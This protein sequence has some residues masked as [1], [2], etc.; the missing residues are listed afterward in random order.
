MTY[1]PRSLTVIALALFCMSLALG[2]WVYLPFSNALYQD[3][4]WV[5]MWISEQPLG[6]QQPLTWKHVLPTLAGATIALFFFS[7]L[8]NRLQARRLAVAC[9]ICMFW[10]S[11]P[12]HVG[13]LQVH[14]PAAYAF[15]C[16]PVLIALLAAWRYPRFVWMLVLLTLAALALAASLYFQ[17]LPIPNPVA[18]FVPSASDVGPWAFPQ[19]FSPIVELA[20]LLLLLLLLMP[21][22]NHIAARLPEASTPL[23]V[24]A[25]LFVVRN[26][27]VGSELV[28]VRANPRLAL[29]HSLAYAQANPA[30]AWLAVEHFEFIGDEDSVSRYQDML[31]LPLPETTPLSYRIAVRCMV[32]GTYDDG[33]G[34][35]DPSAFLLLRHMQLSGR[36]GAGSEAS[37]QHVP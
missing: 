27:I 1:S 30:L 3:A 18:W 5:L 17:R 28:Q 12:W 6:L 9:V 31:R 37:S 16:V 7:M 21:A 34:I 11:S 26:F 4:W 25:F 29:L 36:C 19:G 24:L 33:G 32:D 22:L 20:Y 35:K 8:S 10:V 23:L 14:G 2:L 13:V 15:V